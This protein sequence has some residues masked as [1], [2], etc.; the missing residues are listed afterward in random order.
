[1]PG[2]GEGEQHHVL[3]LAPMERETSTKVGFF[4]DT[5][6]CDSD[7]LP[8]LGMLLEELVDKRRH[9]LELLGVTGEEAEDCQI[10]DFQPRSMYQNFRGASADLGLKDMESV[11]QARHGGACRDLKLKKRSTLEVQMR[12]HWG[13]NASFRIYH[14]PARVQQLLNAMSEEVRQYALE[15]Q[16]TFVD[17]V[18]SGS[19]P[20]PPVALGT[21]H[22]S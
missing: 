7:V 1:M 14:K 6:I 15:V 2:S 3:V 18:R 11:Y 20:R 5:V 17:S 4:D 10:F 12:G 13:T 9:D 8:E 19:F 21:H 16:R 22:S